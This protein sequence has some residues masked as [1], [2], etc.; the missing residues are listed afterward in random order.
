VAYSRLLA[1]STVAVLLV[2]AAPAWVATSDPIAAQP[3]T[4]VGTASAATFH[5]PRPSTALLSPSTQEHGPR[6]CAELRCYR[7]G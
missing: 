4:A 7:R 1:V 3:L 6:S 2:I 5:S